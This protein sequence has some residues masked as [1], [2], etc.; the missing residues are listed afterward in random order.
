M[1]YDEFTDHSYVKSHA[2][3]QSS[4]HSGIVIPSQQVP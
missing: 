3:E 2:F 4:G 1:A